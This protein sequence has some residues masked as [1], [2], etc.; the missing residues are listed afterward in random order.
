VRCLTRRPEVLAGRSERSTTVVA[1]DA[2]VPDSLAAAL[3]GV[4]LAY[5]LV[6]SMAAGDRFEVLDRRAALGF[7][8]AAR[9]AGVGQIVYLGALGSEPD[10]SRHLA[11]RQE[12]GRILRSSGVPTLE[13]RASI[14]MAARPTKRY[15]RSSSSSRS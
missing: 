2:L 8:A 10:L 7:A 5:Y 6:H 12:V 4:A 11:S 14:V 1:G 3:D 13:L 9:A 15:A